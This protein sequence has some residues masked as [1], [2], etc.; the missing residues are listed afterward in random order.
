MSQESVWEREYENPQLVTGGTEPQGD[1]KRFIK[2]LRKDQK[3]ALEG[4]RVLDLGSG[5]GKNAIFL[6]ERGA[7]VTGLEISPKAIGTAEQRAEDAGVEVE[8]LLHDIGSH[9]SFNDASF[10]VAL[11]IMS[12]NSLDEKGRAV[13]LKEAD[14][15]LKPGGYVF[16]RLLC[17]DGDKN[18]ENLLRDHPG[19]EKDTYVMP[20]LK[21]TERV[22]SKEDF[23]TLYSKY[24]KIIKLER[25]SGYAQFAGRV[26]KRNYWVGYMQK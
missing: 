17:K 23:T 5:L 20:G 18:A 2:W 6:A 7:I 11:D 10:D 15:V 12:S 14:R 19:K 21:L 26:Y 22:F 13:Y 3:R 9:Y 4:L 24:F 25:K 8:F 16:V 1:V